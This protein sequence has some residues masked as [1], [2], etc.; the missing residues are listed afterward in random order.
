MA[1]ANRRVQELVE[2][3]PIVVLASHDRNMMIDLCNRGLVLQS[4]RLLFDGPIADALGHYDEIVG[5]AVA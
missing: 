4:G 5:A 2:R 1:K 3:S